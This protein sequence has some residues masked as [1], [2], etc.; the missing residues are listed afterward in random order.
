MVTAS[1]EFTAH[2]SC[3]A[4]LAGMEDSLHAT[5][6]ISE[7]YGSTAGVLVNPEL[8]EIVREGLRRTQKQLP[9]WLFYD[10]AGS[11][12]F[13]QITTLPE[14]YLTRLE[15]EIF[16]NDAAEMI[17]LAAGEGQLRVLELGAGSADKTR[18]LL[19][20]ATDFQGRVCYQPVDVSDTALEAA[21]VRLGQELP[22]V[23]VEPHVADYT[24]GLQ[25]QPCAE[26]EKRLALFI[27]S[28]IGNFLPEDAQELLARLHTALQPGDGL[29]LGVDLAPTA[30]QGGKS[31]ELLKAAYDDAQGVTAAFNMNMLVRLNRDLGAEFDLSA[32]RHRIHWNEHE[33]RIEMHL[34]SLQDQTVR[35]PSL[36]M[37]VEF[38]KGESIH[39]EN[40]YKYRIGEVEK[41][42]EAAGFVA[43]QRWRDENGWFAVYLATRA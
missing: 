12:L 27:G 40:S 2:S 18:L 39:T 24:R 5:S 16:A 4:D 23:A 38:R 26:G 13:D 19:A 43:P 41:L 7:G 17:A 11:L 35:I 32:F 29:L 21:R 1:L 34:E 33:S 3:P 30:E 9:P 25:L 22:E 15:R 20:A 6:T 10:E 28:S 36:D 14:Y 31:E 42:L 37:E 8:G